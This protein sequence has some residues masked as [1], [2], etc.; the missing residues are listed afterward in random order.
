MPVRVVML[1][2]P[3]DPACLS[4]ISACLAELSSGRAERAALILIAGENCGAGADDRWRMLCAAASCSKQLIPL[5]LPPKAGPADGG[6]LKRFVRK[7]I[8]DAA[9]YQISDSVPGEG[10]CPSVAEYTALKQLYGASSYLEGA[11]PWVDQLFEAL[12]PHRFAHSLAVARTSVELALRF[13]IDPVKA[14]E[15]GLLHDCAKCLSLPEMQKTVRKH[16]M[17]VDPDLLSASSLLHSLAGACVA[18]DRYG[19]EDPEILEAI[20]Y[21]NTGHEGMSPLA[22]VV[23][24]ADFMEPNREP[25]PLLEEVRA[26]AQVS[27]DRALLLSLEGVA[28]H[29]SSKGKKL[30]PRTLNTIAWL[31]TII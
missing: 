23:C 20:E 2:D 6:S 16:R 30:H 28:A 10:L 12:N 17:A 5:R 11:G 8:P 13:G 25:F 27:L 15:A 21:H 3:F 24:L 19:V 26:L 9:P 1:A 18:Q 7:K 4:H 22:R 31:K 29:V 14:E